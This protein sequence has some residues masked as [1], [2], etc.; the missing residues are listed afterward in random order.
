MIALKVYAAVGGQ[1]LKLGLGFYPFSDGTESEC[2][3]Q[4]DNGRTNFGVFLLAGT[5]HYKGAIDFQHIH[6][7]VFKV[8]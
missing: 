7:Q 6:R 1:E 3:S 4:F 5:F 2:R 8:V